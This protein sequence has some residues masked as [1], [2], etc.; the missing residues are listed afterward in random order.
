MENVGIKYYLKGFLALASGFFN[1]RK[2]PKICFVLGVVISFLFISVYL[3]ILINDWYRTFWDVLQNYKFNEFWPQVGRFTL[4][5][6]GYVAIGVYSVYLQ[7]MIQIN[8]REY[9]TKKA[10]N[11]WLN[12]EAYY[13][14]KLLYKDVDNP[15][16]RISEDINQFIALTL[17]LT[18]GIINQALT[19]VAFV[20]VLWNISGIFYVSI[21]SREI[22]IHGYMVW[23]SLIYS[24]IGTVLTHKV[25]KI[26]ISLNYK[27][28]TCEA[29]FRFSMMRL[30]ENSDSIA[31]YRGEE[32]EYKNFKEKFSYL[33]SNFRHIMVRQKIL[34]A[35]TVGYNQLAIIIPILFIAPK[36]FLASVQVGWIMQVLNAFSQVQGA[37]SYFVSAYSN[38]AQWCAV[39]QRLYHFKLHTIE[40]KNLKTKLQ[41][42][43][44]KDLKLT[45]VNIFLPDG[46]PL[47]KDINFSME[48]IDSLIISGKSGAGKSTMLK[49][50]ANL[51]P[52]ATGYITLQ[53]KDQILFLP[54]KPYLPMGSLKD[55]I[56][57]P[58]IWQDTFKD[59]IKKYLEL[60]NMKTL[61]DKLDVVED[62]TKI[63]S[64][65]EQQR[66][67]FIRVFL[68]K[69]QY[70]FLDEATSALDEITE[71]T[72][73]KLIKQYLPHTKIISIG[74][75]STLYAHHSH[76]LIFK[77][78]C[79]WI[80]TKI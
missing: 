23:L 80:I 59:D 72:M 41:F 46:K 39:V 14:L 13:K 3:T 66:I 2:R 29:D 61:I 74:H 54:Q 26:L 70:V 58:N 48:N 27:Q 30:R 21:F 68:Y 18:L 49:A 37:L 8:W 31:F 25:G 7:Q 52:Y 57:Y 16:Q 50:I 45:N 40:A 60:V 5:A 19:L 47:V 36:W 78:N 38:V 9:M 43:K 77:E 69:P 4:I 67:A 22:P 17:S 33:V 34:N 63:L 73:Y 32:P 53:S 42:N 76:K 10:L 15:D 62:Y 79:K 11:D 75:R 44:G 71:E 35:F 65:G 24:I 51:W 6:F 12:N 28:Q 64:L 56:S 1:I 55:A 20:V